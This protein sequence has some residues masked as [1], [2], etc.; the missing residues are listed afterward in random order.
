MLL[1]IIDFQ[2]LKIKANAA[3]VKIC[4]NGLRK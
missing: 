1:D 4:I 2:E 3:E